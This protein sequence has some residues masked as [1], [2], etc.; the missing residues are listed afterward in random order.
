[1]AALQGRSHWDRENVNA[2][3]NYRIEWIAGRDKL[4]LNN[5][6]DWAVAAG[7]VFAEDPDLYKRYRAVNTVCVSKISVMD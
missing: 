4:D 3:V 7:K 6:A 1:V 2:T 5:P